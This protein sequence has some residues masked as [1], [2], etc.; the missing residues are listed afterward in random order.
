MLSPFLLRLAYENKGGALWKTE[1][2]LKPIRK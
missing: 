2:N 1:G